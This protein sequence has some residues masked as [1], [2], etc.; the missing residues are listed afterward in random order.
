MQFLRKGI[1]IIGLILILTLAFP[2]SPTKATEK[3]IPSR[4]DSREEGYDFPVRDQVTYSVGYAFAGVEAVQAAIWKKEKIQVDLSENNA[5]RC[6]WHKLNKFDS[7]INKGKDFMIISNLFTQKGLVLESCD[8]Y[9]LEV[10]PVCNQ[11]CEAVYYVTE[12]QHITDGNNDEIKSLLLEYGPVYSEMDGYI[13]GFEN[14]GGGEV[15]VYEGTL[16]DFWHSVLIIGWDDDLTHKNGKGAWIVKNSY[17]SDWGDDGYFYLA[18]G[19]AG[20]GKDVAVVT[21]YRKST[22]TDRLYFFDEAGHTNQWGFDVTNLK[23]GSA[24]AI[25]TV[26]SD[27]YTRSVEFWT[28]DQATV[29]LALYSSFDQNIFGEK[30][31]ALTDYQ[32]PYAGYYSIDLPFLELAEGQE[33]VVELEVTNN[34]EFFPIT[35]DC[36]GERSDERT[37]YK[38]QFGVWY[39]LSQQECDAAIR[40]RTGEITEDFS[41]IY[42]PIL[43]R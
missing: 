7:L 15:I 25:F 26:N 22:P 30:I 5:I 9:E 17:G 41:K 19:S 1:L 27:E 23:Q 36:L 34:T 32:T 8:P 24:L 33:I 11:S 21:G 43:W 2:T 4:F 13:P 16:S 6:N 28:Y 31:H 18:Y 29:N 3:S 12:W 40:L 39:P 14:F 35:T 38:D 42:L 10:D 20:I 37:W